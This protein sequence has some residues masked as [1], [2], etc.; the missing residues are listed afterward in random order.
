MTSQRPNDA[1]AWLVLVSASLAT[2]IAGWLLPASVH[3]V[4]WEGPAATRVALVPPFGR[5]LLLVGGVVALGI[6]LGVAAA[7]RGRLHELSTAVAPLILLGLWL[8][9]YLPVVADYAPLLLA[10]E[11]PLRWVVAALALGG[12]VFLASAPWDRPALSSPQSRT[13]FVVSLV[14][15]G[16]IPSFF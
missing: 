8:V 13:V 15:F 4:G 11:G 10:L 12:C 2:G 7:R 5:L 1:R 14:F 6:G 3:I 16:T 9:P